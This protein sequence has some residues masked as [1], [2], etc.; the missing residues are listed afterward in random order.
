MISTLLSRR[1]GVP[2]RKYYIWFIFL[3]TCL[4]QAFLFPNITLIAGERANL[5]SGVLCFAT[6]ISALVILKIRANDIRVSEVVISIILVCLAIISSTLSITPGVSF[7]RSFV[8]ISSMIGGYWISRLLL[9]TTEGRLFFQKFCLVLLLGIMVLTALSLLEYGKPFIL[10]DTGS[11]QV[12][13]RMLILS[14]APIHLLFASS[15]PVIIGAAIILVMMYACLVVLC[16]YVRVKSA[17]IIPFV[18]I[19]VVLIFVKKTKPLALGLII[20]FFVSLIG[21]YKQLDLSNALTKGAASVSQRIE[22]VF[23]SFHIAAKNPFFGIGPFAPRDQYLKDYQ[24][25]YP[26]LSKNDFVTWSQESLTSESAYLTF[27]ADLGFPFVILYLSAFFCLLWKL[28]HLAWRPPSHY[29]PAPLALLLAITGSFIH[30][31]VF[32]G[33]YLPQ[34][35]WFFHILLGMVLFNPPETK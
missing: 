34:I 20:F 26:S 16:S 33:P 10:I 22:N 30:F 17:L 13:S 15:I 11:H 35:S 19:P 8:I 9:N 28:A 1:L 14:F 18:L 5:F 32:D 2:I 25:R 6:F 27:L 12:I 24:I 3:L 21:A 31:Q 23:Y 7:A 29:T 4:Q